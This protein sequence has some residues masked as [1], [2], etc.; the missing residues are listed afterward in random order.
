VELGRPFVTLLVGLQFLQA[1]S[2]SFF[3]LH[4]LRDF[5]HAAYV[6]CKCYLVYALCVCALKAGNV[7]WFQIAQRFGTLSEV[8]RFL[9]LLCTNMFH[10]E[11]IGLCVQSCDILRWHSTPRQPSTFPI[12][13]IH[14]STVR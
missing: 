4:V 5:R 3:S 1:A 13:P 8:V 7:L 2:S 11:W 14:I 9:L 10:A 12:H 6:S